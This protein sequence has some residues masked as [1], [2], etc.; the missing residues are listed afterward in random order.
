MP[1]V[2][3]DFSYNIFQAKTMPT[4]KTQHVDRP[5]PSEYDPY[6]AGYVALAE[7]TNL[8]ALLQT[9]YDETQ[10]MIRPLN[11]EKLMY[12]YAEGKWT[13]K[14]ILLHIADAER[15]FCYRALRFARQDSTPLSGFNEGD[16]TPVSGALQRSLDSL[17]DELSSVRLATLSLFDNFIPE[18]LRSTGIA[19]D[20]AVSVRALGYMIAGHEIHHRNIIRERYLQ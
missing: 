7:G 5:E 19:S 15:I 12:R 2:G 9:S 4:Y 17:L 3:V 8:I 6:A 10:A 18:M 1:C 16:Y 13:I 14:E 11:E 20:K